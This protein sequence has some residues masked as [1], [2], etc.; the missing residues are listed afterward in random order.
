[1]AETG[2]EDNDRVY[3][4]SYI[5]RRGNQH[6]NK[7]SGQIEKRTADEFRYLPYPD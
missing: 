7:G 1:M 5:V 2:E 4:I 6:V 3:I